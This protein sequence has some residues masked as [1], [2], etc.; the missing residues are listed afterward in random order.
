M[1]FHANPTLNGGE[2]LGFQQPGDGAWVMQ[3]R[4]QIPIFRL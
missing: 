4:R 2:N 1:G 3:R